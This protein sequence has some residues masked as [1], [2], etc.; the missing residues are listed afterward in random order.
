MEAKERAFWSSGIA[1][2]VLG[3]AVA[4]ITIGVVRYTGVEK[5]PW[6]YIGV[7]IGILSAVGGGV[8]TLI[9]AREVSE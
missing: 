6:L 2:V 4:M 1:V 8:L 3:F 9:R 7:A 5:Q